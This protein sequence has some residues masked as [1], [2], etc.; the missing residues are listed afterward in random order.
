MQVCSPATVMYR[1]CI[2]VHSCESADLCDA[3]TESRYAH[4]NRIC[5]GAEEQHH[6]HRAVYTPHT[7]G[8]SREALHPAGASSIIGAV[9][10]ILTAVIT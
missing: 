9:E 8:H 7:R 5:H 3:L 2:A 4:S 10:G 6:R 1:Q